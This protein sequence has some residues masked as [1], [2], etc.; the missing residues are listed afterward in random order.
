MAD[1]IFINDDGLKKC[2]DAKTGRATSPIGNQTL[3]LF[4]APTSVSQVN[5]VGDF[6]EATFPGY[7]ANQLQGPSW[8]APTL[9]AH[10][11]SSL[12]GA[13]IIFTRNATGSPQTV[14]GWFITDAGKTGVYA[15]ALFASG[16]YTF[17][18]NGDSVSIV[19]TLTE[20]S[21]N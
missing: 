17:T 9:A 7:V 5:V 19:P 3:R 15:C 13:S 16:P 18:N 20:Q 8:G 6:T 4:T 21:L 1:T 14:Y 10:V 12:Y 11:A 2:L